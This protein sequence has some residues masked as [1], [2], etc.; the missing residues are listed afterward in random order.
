MELQ[1][2][3]AFFETNKGSEEVKAYLSGLSKITVEAAEQFANT[4]DGKRWINPKLDKNF[5]KGLD[6]WKTGNLQK[7]IDDAVSKA[8]P[9]ETPEQKQI[10]ELTDR[11]NQKESAEKRQQ[12]LNKGLSHADTKKL[13]RDLVEYFI[14]EDEKTTLANIDKLGL[15]FDPFVKAEVEAR[16]KSGYKPAGGAGGST[17]MTKEE[18]QKLTYTERV[19]LSKDNPDQ[20][21]ELK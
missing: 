2:I 11:L 1:D 6:T 20:Y 13:P 8:N 3:I 17:A 5:T 10:R 19:K 7:L 16:L 15:A 12:L 14:G 18:F 4:E 21:K 9:T